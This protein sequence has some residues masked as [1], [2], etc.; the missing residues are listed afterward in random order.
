MA[1]GDPTFLHIAVWTL[2][3]L[4]EA[5]DKE[6]IGLIAKSEEIIQMVKTISDKNIESDEDEGEEGE[7]EVVALAQRALEL[8]GKG[9]KQTLVE[10]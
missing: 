9:P 5:G 8:L 10:G 1:S 4:I 2:L 6:L 7:G 3:Q